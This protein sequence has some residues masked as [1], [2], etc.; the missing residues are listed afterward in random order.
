MIRIKYE[1]YW[2]DLRRENN[3][4]KTFYGLK[5]LEDWLFNNAQFSTIYKKIDVY[6]PVTE[7]TSWK[8]NPEPSRIESTDNDGWSTWVHVIE[9]DNG[10][11]FSDGKYTAWQKHWN[12]EVKAWLKHCG[13]RA[14]KPRFNFV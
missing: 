2:N 13:E 4:T 3:L 5:E 11:I 8:S 6:F 1:R 7:P 12:D 14:T 9:N 10:I